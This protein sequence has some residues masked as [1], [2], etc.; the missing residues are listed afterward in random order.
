MK[1]AVVGECKEHRE[2]GEENEVRSRECLGEHH[3][4]GKS[5]E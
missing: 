5:K 2:T 4:M 3:R 1:G